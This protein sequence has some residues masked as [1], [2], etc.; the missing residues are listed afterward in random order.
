MRF[1]RCRFM[2]NATHPTAPKAPGAPATG[3]DVSTP[4]MA[5]SRAAPDRLSP[6][7]H[8]QAPTGNAAPVPNDNDR[9]TVSLRSGVTTGAM[10]W[11]L[12][13]GVALAV[14]ALGAAWL[15]NAPAR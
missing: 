6:V 11:V 2:T 10:R 9:A 12:G 4:D 14:L 7:P 5:G 13:G 1:G 15:V 8:P 3:P